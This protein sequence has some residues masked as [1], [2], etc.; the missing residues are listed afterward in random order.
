MSCQ[1]DQPNKWLAEDNV[2]LADVTREDIKVPPSTMTSVM[3]KIWVKKK[4]RF[5][6]KSSYMI[7]FHQRDL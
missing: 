3:V 7:G 4:N 2:R 1:T 5:E 6:V